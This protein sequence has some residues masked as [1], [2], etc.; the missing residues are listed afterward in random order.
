M[1][2]TANKFAKT[3]LRLIKEEHLSIEE[4]AKIIGVSR[5]VIVK[6]VAGVGC[7]TFTALKRFNEAFASYMMED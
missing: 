3:I 4:I 1:S 5:Q 6:W 2:I 7:P